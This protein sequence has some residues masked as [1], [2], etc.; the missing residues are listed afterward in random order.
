MR[1]VPDRG[2][3]SFKKVTPWQLSQAGS[4]M[5]FKEMQLFLSYAPV[6]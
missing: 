4:V 6:V 5:L 2:F 3:P 1:E